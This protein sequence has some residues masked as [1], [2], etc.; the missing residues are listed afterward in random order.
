VSAQRQSVSRPLAFVALCLLSVAIVATHLLLRRSSAKLG[1]VDS[2]IPLATNIAVLGDR[3]GLLFTS[4][5]FDRTNGYLGLALLG[6]E[7]TGRYRTELRC[8]RVH[9]AGG[10]GL[11][12][13]A[14]RGVITTFTAEIF[15]PDFRVRYSLPLKGGVPSRARVSPDGRRGA[16]TVFVGGD[17][18]AST[19]FSTRTTL[20]DMTSGNVIADLE[21]FAVTR[22]GEAFRAV[23][24]NFWGVT[25]AQDGNRFFAT[26][27]TAGRTY[28]V[29]GNVDTR[30]V[31][32]LRANV[33]CPSL[34]PD[35]KRIVFKKRVGQGSWRLH[36]LDL[37]T[38]VDVP[39]GEGRSV[40]DQVEWLDNER[41]AYMLPAGEN[42]GAGSDIWVLSIRE[43]RSPALLLLRGYSPVAVLP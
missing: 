2:E 33:E 7:S 36:V 41:V 8:E 40:D 13:A 31:H 29:E 30:S 25:F 39:L 27:G 43:Q 21:Q 14:S 28:L 22:D 19:S 6:P 12:L 16:F 42:S 18:Y 23:D 26:L 38:L 10:V 35:G 4:A 24:F 15:G 9:F 3:S 17:S 37:T 32:V 11:C 34:S 20:L 1:S 5:T